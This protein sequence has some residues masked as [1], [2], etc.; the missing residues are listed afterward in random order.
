MKKL[1]SLISAVLLAGIVSASA[2]QAGAWS[3]KQCI[4]YAHENNI[5]LQMRKNQTESGRLAVTEAKSGYIPTLSAGMNQSWNLGRGLTAENTYANRN[6]SNF[7]YSAGLNVPIFSGLR[8]TRQVAYA[9]ANLAQITEQYEA[10]KEDITVNIITAYLQV[11]YNKELNEVAAQQ[12]ALSEYELSRREALMQAGKIPEADRLEAV[13]QLE[14]D[15]MNQTQTANDVTLS[16]IDLAQLLQL[17]NV[18]GFDILP[19]DDENTMIIPAEEAYQRALQFNH[20]IE[21]ARKGITSAEK[22][23][24]LAKSGYLPTLSFNAGLGS[25]YYKISGMPNDGFGTQ[26]KNNYSTNFGFSL[27]IPIFDGFQTRNSVRRAKVEKIN[28]ELE[29]EQAQQTLY[30]TIQQAYYQA[31]SAEKKLTSATAAREAA[32]AAFESMQEKYSLGR[33]TPYEY[34]QAKTK[35]LT[36]TAQQIQARYELIMRSRILQFY[37]QEH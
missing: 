18:D 28:A 4:D 15:R 32:D 8:T 25:S 29:L 20:S 24:T 22:S 14:S 1:Y 26:M 13:S 9:K 3:L 31:I 35:A 17:E 11:L 23:I 27:S 7:S 36:T 19:L 21:A 33:A 10:A 12:V 5:T 37:S 2:Q 34:E 16:L 30:R 6:T